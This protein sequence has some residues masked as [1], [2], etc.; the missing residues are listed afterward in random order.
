M[1]FLHVHY[2]MCSRRERNSQ[3]TE[4]LESFDSGQAN[5]PV[6]VSG[7]FEINVSPLFHA[8]EEE[9]KRRKHKHTLDEEEEDDDE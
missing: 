4:T 8:Y 3:E 6:P 1:V 7:D 2:E 5:M 9:R